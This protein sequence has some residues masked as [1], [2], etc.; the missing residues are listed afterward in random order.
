[1]F[2]RTE[3]LFLR[4]GWPEER[5]EL[6]ALISGIHGLSDDARARIESQPSEMFPQFCITVPGEKGAQLIGGIELV[7]AAGAGSLAFW[8][9]QPFRGQGFATEAVR[10]VLNLARTLGHRR[11]VGWHF[12]DDAASG[13]VLGKTGFSSTGHIRMCLNPARGGGEPALVHA[14]ELGADG[15]IADPDAMKC[16]A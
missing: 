13:R 16:A 3:R 4:P 2:I 5:A 6:A 9:A 8:I 10:A 7:D 15:T 1:M 11:I 12:V 14:V